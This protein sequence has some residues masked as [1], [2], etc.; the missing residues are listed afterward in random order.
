[1]ARFIPFYMTYYAMLA[2]YQSY[3]TV[4][5]KDVGLNSA[6]IGNVMAAAPVSALLGQLVWSK[7]G[8]SMKHKNTLLMLLIGAAALCIL[9]C[10]L[11]SNYIYLIFT[12]GLFSFFYLAVQP[13]GDT[14]TLETL[15]QQSLPFGPV[16]MSANVSFCFI[17]A[18]SGA[19]MLTNIGLI[20]YMVCALFILTLGSVFFMPKV[21]GHRKAGDKGSFR[22]LLSS[23]ELVMLLLFA[24]CM[25]IGM[26]FF[27]NY[28]SIYFTDELGGSGTA[29]G[30]C[31][32]ISAASE[33]P[34]LLFSDRLFKKFGVGAILTL[35]ATMMCLRWLVLFS[36]Q[37][38]QLAMVS[39]LMHSFC[40]LMMSFAMSK[41]I[42]NTVEDK[43]QAA[44]QLLYTLFTLSI[45]RILGSFLGGAISQAFGIRTLFLAGAL[46]TF[47][48][49]LVFVPYIIRHRKQLVAHS[50]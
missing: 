8:D 6:Q 37:S 21:S 23:R 12:V 5:L 31:Y 24:C 1:M 45:A 25:M 35:S 44:G 9:L 16:R 18:I 49:M 40:F 17:S 28:F 19:F 34:F 46:F 48:S 13:M 47:G 10:N 20:N 26:S 22:A 33:V 32:F 43:Y 7:A 38:W 29:L 39:Q 4:Y 3:F 41:Y 11:S 36:V 14:I 15:A 42:A 2:I 30:W 27:Y 50:R